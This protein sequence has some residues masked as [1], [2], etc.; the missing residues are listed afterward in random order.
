MHIIGVEIVAEIFLCEHNVYLALGA[1][2][3]E[4]RLLGA[5]TGFL[6]IAFCNII[7][8]QLQP[9]LIVLQ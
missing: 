5:E 9:C 8:L 3:P 4:P 6:E 2:L 1:T 7:L